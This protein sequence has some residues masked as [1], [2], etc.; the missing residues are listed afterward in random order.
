MGKYEENIKQGEVKMKPAARRMSSLL[1]LSLIMQLFSGVVDIT[2]AEAVSSQA[3]NQQ[4]GR[5]AQ[6]LT[7]QLESTD[8]MESGNESQP[9]P[10]EPPESFPELPEESV[11]RPEETS[12]ESPESSQPVESS[13][14]DEASQESS[15]SSSSSSGSK[16]ITSTNQPPVQQDETQSGNNLTQIAPGSLMIKPANVLEPI[17]IA[18]TVK[19]LTTSYYEVALITIKSGVLF[20]QQL[21]FP[22]GTIVSLKV[23]KQLTSYFESLLNLIVQT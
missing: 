17:N 23:S 1:S 2:S 8:E 9:G 10:P 19:R 11:S 4:Y 7:V 15:E 13:S 21:M 14:Q 22:P 16:P 3:F 5:P 12:G 20:A 18:S 6:Y